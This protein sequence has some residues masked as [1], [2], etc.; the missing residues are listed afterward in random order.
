V[1]LYSQEA[2]AKV[3]KAQRWPPEDLAQRCDQVLKTGG[4]LTRLWPEVERERLCQDGRRSSRQPR[5]VGEVDR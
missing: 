3:E 5:D 4:A 2:V 1:V